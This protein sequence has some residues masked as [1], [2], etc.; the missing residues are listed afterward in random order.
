M[1]SLQLGNDISSVRIG[2]SGRNLITVTDYSSYVFD[3][4]DQLSAIAVNVQQKTTS[5]LFRKKIVLLFVKYFSFMR[6]LLSCL[7]I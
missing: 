6:E 2:L 1:P 7:F 3:R 5:K 4:N